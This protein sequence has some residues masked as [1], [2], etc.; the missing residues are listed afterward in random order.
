MDCFWI[1]APTL[2]SHARPNPIYTQQLQKLKAQSPPLQNLNNSKIAMPSA[3]IK[4]AKPEKTLPIIEDD[5]I[6]IAEV[7]SSEESSEESGDCVL[8][9]ASVREGGKG[10]GRLRPAS[11]ILSSIDSVVSQDFLKK[12]YN[13]KRSLDSFLGPEQPAFEISE[14]EMDLFNNS[15]RAHLGFALTKEPKR[16]KMK[17][18][19]MIFEDSESGG[20]AQGGRHWGYH[21]A[22]NQRLLNSNT[23][24]AELERRKEEK[25]RKREGRDVRRPRDGEKCERKAKATKRK[26][27]AAE[28]PLAE[29]FRAFYDLTDVAHGS[30]MRAWTE[31]DDAAQ[32]VGLGANAMESHV[33]EWRNVRAD[34][35]YYQDA[36]QFGAR[37]STSNVG[38]RLLQK[39]GW[40]G[41]GTG[42]GREGKGIAKPIIPRAVNGRRGLCAKQDL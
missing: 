34:G 37:I 7:P 5:C 18:T 42:L 31:D 36:D 9:G 1:E 12:E 20:L 32:S 19:A 10:I 25:R 29:S 22:Q 16:K 2:A 33:I 40:A 26:K 13:N 23:L 17:E 28:T 6:Y 39:A 35:V 15:M 38:Y 41:F 8:V 14:E 27:S 11:A 4:Q 24:L 21:T 3:P 30:R